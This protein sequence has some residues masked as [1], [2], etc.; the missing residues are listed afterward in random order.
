MLSLSGLISNDNLSQDL[1]N[2][3]V[4]I[5]MDNDGEV[6]LIEAS[7]IPTGKDN[8]GEP[9][10][11]EGIAAASLTVMDGELSL[12]HPAVYA[13][14]AAVMWA[15]SI[16]CADYISNR[17]FLFN[18]ASKSFVVYE[19]EWFT[20]MLLYLRADDARAAG[21]TVGYYEGYVILAAKHE[22]EM[23][24]MADGA[25]SY[26]TMFYDDFARMLENYPAIMV[27]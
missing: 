14:A 26:V 5:G 17:G 21:F 16:D 25:G 10:P 1:R 13:L 24:V 3:R 7:L 8:Y 2:L 6:F 4:D 11:C 18:A 22:S 12:P 9:V 23:I 27:D 19:A 20:L 15:A